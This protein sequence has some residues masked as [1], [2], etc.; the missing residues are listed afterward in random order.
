MS[1]AA[2][3]DIENIQT[4]YCGYRQLPIAR[5]PD[6]GYTIAA[7]AVRIILIVT[8]MLESPSCGIE[9]VQTAVGGADPKR[10]VRVFKE[11]RHVITG[12]RSI[13]LRRVF[14]YDEIVAV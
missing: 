12:D 9:S 14:E 7:Q 13:I 5:A 1:E 8:I 10:A 4:F 11:S 2:G 3:L 6:G